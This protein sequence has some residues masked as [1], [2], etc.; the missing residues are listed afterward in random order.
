[1]REQHLV[2]RKMKDEFK[3]GELD[4]ILRYGAKVSIPVY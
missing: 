3:D 4:D 2:V 1:M